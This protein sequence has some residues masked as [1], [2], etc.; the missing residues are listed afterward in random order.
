MVVLLAF[1]MGMNNATLTVFA[2]LKGADN[3]AEIKSYLS[4][5]SILLTVLSL[6]IGLSGFFLTEP[7]LALLNTPEPIID[8]AK[9]Y[10]Q[11]M[12]IGTLFLTGYNFIGSLLRAFGDSKTP[13]YFVLLATVLTAVLNP[14]FIAGF[15]LGIAGA[16][17]AMILAQTLPFLSSLTYLS[18]LSRTGLLPFGLKSPKP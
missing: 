6:T 8:D 4:A 10:L 17:W 12:F 7:L 2:Q 9:Q 15:D 13:M 5:F 16:A 11:I 14:L 1:V 18:G 3:Q